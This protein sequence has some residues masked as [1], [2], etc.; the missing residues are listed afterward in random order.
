MNLRI[1]ALDP[2]T[3]DMYL[4]MNGDF[5][6]YQGRIDE[7]AQLLTCKLQTFLGEIPTNL[8]KGVDY[9]RIIFADFIT[10]QSKINELVRVILET[11]G[12]ENIENFNISPDRA[13][14]IMGYNFTIVT[15]AG[16]IQFQD[17]L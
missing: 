8:I 12:V 6:G 17:L 15:D 9:H 4:D 5:A 14:G 2:N 16:E 3:N 10:E 13:K 11:D 1:F 7:I